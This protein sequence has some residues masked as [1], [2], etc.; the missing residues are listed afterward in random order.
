MA[1]INVSAVNKMALEAAMQLWKHQP[2]AAAAAA[3]GCVLTERLG[4]RR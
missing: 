3:I 1:E 2:D 4:A